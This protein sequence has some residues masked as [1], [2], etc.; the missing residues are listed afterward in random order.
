MPKKKINRKFLP[1]PDKE[2]RQDEKT[3]NFF[4]RT[5][6]FPFQICYNETN[7]Y[8]K[9]MIPID[10]SAIAALSTSMSMAETQQAAAISVMQK[11]MDS[12]EMQAVSLIQDLQAANP[13]PSF[14]HKLDVYA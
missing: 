13:A 2:R 9:R 4:A 7:T 10:V 8:R 11:V 6:V 1:K 5:L 3:G 14:G 12:Q